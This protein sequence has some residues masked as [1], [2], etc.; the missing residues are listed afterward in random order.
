MKQRGVTLIELMVALVIGLLLSLAAASMA[1]TFD[2]GRRSNIASNISGVNGTTSLSTL[3][4]SLGMAGT[5]LVYPG[6][7]GEPV[8][9]CSTVYAHEGVTLSGVTIN[10]VSI[11]ASKANSDRLTFAY[12][13][14]GSSSSR[15]RPA[16]VLAA[17]NDDITVTANGAINAGEDIFLLSGVDKTCT[18]R[19]VTTLTANVPVAPATGTLTLHF[20]ASAPHNGSVGSPAPIYSSYFV[21]PIKQLVYQEWY[22]ED[23]LLKFNNRLANTVNI[24]ADGALYLRAQYGTQSGTSDFGWQDSS[25]V[26]INLKAIRTALVVQ[27]GDQEKQADPANCTRTTDPNI[28]LGAWLDSAGSPITVDISSLTTTAGGNLV[29]NWQCFYYKTYTS[30][31]PLRSLMWAIT[32]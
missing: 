23:K 32:P 9:T 24:V 26:P 1:I 14:G 20:D 4:A 17:L 7:G 31:T 18:L 10:P 11:D 12:T 16:A 13:T 25:T 8:T 3:S 21:A 30:I 5:G 27:G 6:V 29:P 2:S 28:A 15:L 22:V 19:T